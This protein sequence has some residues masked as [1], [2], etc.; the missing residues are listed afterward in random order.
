MKMSNHNILTGQHN[1]GASHAPYGV[2]ASPVVRTEIEEEKSQKGIFHVTWVTHNSRVSERMVIFGIKKGPSVWLNEESE[3]KIT[4]IIARLVKENKY[5][6]LAYNICGDHVHIILICEEDEIPKIVRHL[7]SVSS[8][9]YHVWR[10]M[11]QTSEETN[12][13][14]CPI[15]RGTTQNILWAQKY[16]ISHITSEEQLTESVSYV[17]H[18]REKHR[19]PISSQLQKIIKKMCI[20]SEE[21]LLYLSD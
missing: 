9:E 19:L 20:P 18:N 2:T 6:V 21:Y 14:A 7:K 3:I 1:K 15:D 12:N 10:G 13:G 5:R 11:T 17:Q 16:N 4:E 8:R